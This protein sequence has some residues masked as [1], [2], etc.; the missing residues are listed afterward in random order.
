MLPPLPPHTP[1]HA[2]CP[3]CVSTVR[4]K[5]G[6]TLSRRNEPARD[7]RVPCDHSRHERCPTVR[8]GQLRPSDAMANEAAH[9]HAHNAKVALRTGGYG[10]RR[11]E[12]QGLY[13]LGIGQ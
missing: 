6:H 13:G 11:S 7:V 1:P 4:T 2:S 8:I 3:D 10:M 5:C 9:E 12:S